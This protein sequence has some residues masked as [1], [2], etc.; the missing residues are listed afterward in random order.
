MIV[1]GIVVLVLLISALIA[2]LRGFIREVLTIFGLVGGGIA[3][4]FGGPIF[5]PTVRNWLGVVEGQE[6]EKL[7]DMV[8]YP[9]LA[10]GLAYIS[11][12]IVFVVL[13]SIISH[14]LAEGAKKIGLGAIDRTL[15]VLFGLARGV[16]LLGLLYLPFYYFVDK[17]QTE[18]WFKDSKTQP[19]VQATSAAIAQFFPADAQES[20][21]NAAE[22]IDEA[23]GAR[24]KL[25]EMGLLGDQSQTDQPEQQPLKDGYN[26]EERENMDKIFEKSLDENSNNSGEN[27]EKSDIP[28]YNR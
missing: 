25:E 7:F 4:Y 24:K 5:A 9:M 8:P 13:F 17:D 26:E 19:Y 14:F 11:L 6:P 21:E 20:V 2:F 15:G 28:P 23:S 10:D 18:K 1:D 12:F 22:K 3:A 16:L 27:S